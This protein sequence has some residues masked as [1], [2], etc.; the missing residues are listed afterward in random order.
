MPDKNKK[1]V[2]EL[3]RRGVFRALV[4]YAVVVW[5]AATGLV[6][7][8]PAVGFPD[9]SI[10]VFLITWYLFWRTIT[11]QAPLE[12]DWFMPQVRGKSVLVTD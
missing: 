4:A 7:L 1:L 12:P 11:K 9:W 8:F 5:L 3:N 2:R 6:D 10:R